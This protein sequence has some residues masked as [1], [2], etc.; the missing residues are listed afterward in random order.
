MRA[1][2]KYIR[3]QASAALVVMLSALVISACASTNGGKASNK[4]SS[5]IHSQLAR[6]YMQKGQYDIAEEE[7]KIALNIDPRNSNANYIMALLQL[8]LKQISKADRY[9]RNAVNFDPKNADVAHDYG[10]VLCQTR[11]PYE[12]EKYFKQ[13]A[14]NP[15]FKH[16]QLSLMRAGECLLGVDDV[17]AV[18]Y[19]QQALAID[20][21]LKPALLSMARAQY[22]SEQ[23][24]SARAYLERYLATANASAS[25]LYLGYQIETKLSAGRRTKYYRDKLV[26]EFPSSREA[27]LTR[28]AR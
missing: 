25:S 12:A 22:D 24:L 18:R 28:D 17:L 21:K 16:K 3:A 8:E 15:L 2:L 5:D 4:D 14:A 6:S 23:F 20:P 10:M 27:S 26:N 1:C 9:F 11:R 7:L 13:A 19:L